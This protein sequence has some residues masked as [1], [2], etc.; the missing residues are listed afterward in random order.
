MSE[1]AD[2]TTDLLKQALAEEAQATEPTPGALQQIQARTAAASSASSRARRRW[3]VVTPIGAGVAAAAVILGVTVLGGGD[4]KV[5]EQPPAA[6]RQNDQSAP[7][8][9]A[10]DPNAPA[11]DQVRAWYVGDNAD[12]SGKTPRLFAETHTV[13]DPGD[14]APVA[15]ANEAVAATPIDPDYRNVWPA[16]LGVGSIEKTSGVTS[17][18]LVGDQSGDLP[19]G[20]LLD[21][22]LQAIARSAGLQPGDMFGWSLN[23]TSD[24]VGYSVAP[25]DDVRSYISIDDIVD[26][27][28]LTSPVTALVSGNTF[29]GNVSWQLFDSTQKIVDKGFVTTSQGMWTQAPI[30]LGN[31][32]PGTYELQALETSAEDG[33][34][35]INVDNKTF[36]VG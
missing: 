9:G 5:G 20:R 36:T 3:I 33:S 29:E 26:G 28:T 7:H 17:I 2:D 24:D 21:L 13:T 8:G 12:S 32:D 11:S 22:G 16:G 27:Q 10:Y 19:S 30:E 23:G 4:D 34:Y 18:N 15:A 14:D 6:S 1:H 25:D 35:V 31:L